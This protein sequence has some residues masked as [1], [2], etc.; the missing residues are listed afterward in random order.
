LDV[1]DVDS[2]LV[3]YG[4][5]DVSLKSEK[6]ERERKWRKKERCGHHA[7]DVLLLFLPSPLF[8]PT[9][10]WFCVSLYLGAKYSALQ[11]VVVQPKITLHSTVQLQ[12]LRFKFLVSIIAMQ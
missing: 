11:Y 1:I 5:M 10:K 8:T 9:Y 3:N 2:Q 4:W 6:T 7:D 12:V